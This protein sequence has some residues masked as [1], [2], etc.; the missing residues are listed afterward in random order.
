MLAD[1]QQNE[2]RDSVPLPPGHEITEVKDAQGNTV[3]AAVP[4]LEKGE[5]VETEPAPPVVTPPPAD[6]STKDAPKS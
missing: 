1:Q 4:I 2:K 6:A 3:R 5:A